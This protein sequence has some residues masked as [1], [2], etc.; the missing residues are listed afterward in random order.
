MARNSNR[1]AL[2][3]RDRFSSS[4]SS[5][6][7]PCRRERLY[8][9]DRRGAPSK[10]PNARRCAVVRGRGE[11]AK[12][13]EVRRGACPRSYC[14]GGRRG[15]TWN[16]N[17]CAQGWRD[18]FFSSRSSDAS[19]CRRERLYF[20]DRRGAHSKL[21]NARRCAVVRGRGAP[22]GQDGEVWHATQIGVL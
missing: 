18:R 12:C 3:W 2:G 11:V 9:R 7:S 1:C 15:V 10:W 4:R 5:D 6:P 17:R 13:Q 16:S 14:G 8:F 19:P 22:V 21:P 20:R